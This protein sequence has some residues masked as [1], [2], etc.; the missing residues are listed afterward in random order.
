M[1]NLNSG[2]WQSSPRFKSRTATGVVTSSS[3]LK[4]RYWM[5]KSKSLCWS[6]ALLDSDEQNHVPLEPRLAA[7]V[8][9]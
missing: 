7:M 3:L 6:K 5:R 2:A 4:E 8:K 1:R 9:T